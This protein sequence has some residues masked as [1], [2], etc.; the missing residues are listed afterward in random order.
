MQ[1]DSQVKKE[2]KGNDVPDMLQQ[3]YNHEF[4]ECQHL[5]NKDI[6]DM[7]QEGLKFIEILENGTKLIGGQYQISLSFRNDKVNKSTK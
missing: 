5:V 3:M 6:A 7:S 1:S 4:T 2:M